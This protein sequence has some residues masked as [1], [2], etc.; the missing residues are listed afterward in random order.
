[1]LLYY[2]SYPKSVIFLFILTYS[3]AYKNINK[4]SYLQGLK[5]RYYVKLL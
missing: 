1:M 5:I 3:N 4:N 2:K